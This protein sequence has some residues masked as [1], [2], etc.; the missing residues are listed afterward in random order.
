[1]TA[2][3]LFDAYIIRERRANATPQGAD[4]DWIMSELAH[5][6]CLPLERVREIVASYT[7]NWGAG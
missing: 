6:H 1:M 7:V 3:D 5:E 4:I 2:A